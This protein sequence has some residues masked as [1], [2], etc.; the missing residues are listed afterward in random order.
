MHDLHQG[1]CVHRRHTRTRAGSVDCEPLVAYKLADH[2]ECEVP[3]ACAFV[4][5]PTS[6]LHGVFAGSS[7]ASRPWFQSMAVVWRCAVNTCLLVASV[8]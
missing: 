3:I 8:R 5:L 1:T 7:P 6:G 2:D 4:H